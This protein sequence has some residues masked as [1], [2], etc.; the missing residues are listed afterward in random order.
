MGL[1]G[2]SGTPPG[3]VNFGAML[4]GGLRVAPTTGYYLATFQVAGLVI[5]RR[6]RPSNPEG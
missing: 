1:A 5:A 3:C 2:D 6:A 4:S